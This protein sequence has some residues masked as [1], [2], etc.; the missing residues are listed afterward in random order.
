V[1]ELST[2]LEIILIRHQKI[3]FKNKENNKWKFKMKIININT[4]TLKII[5][6]YLQVSI[7]MVILH[8]I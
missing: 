1:K 2:V 6:P 7:E 4:K 5:N 8:L 3:Y